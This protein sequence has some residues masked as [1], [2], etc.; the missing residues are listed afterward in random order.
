MKSFKK[1]L[2]L[3]LILTIVMTGCGTKKSS[4]NQG[5]TPAPTSE[6]QITA[7]PTTGVEPTT[8]AGLPE[9]TTKNN[10]TKY[11]LTITDTLGETI[12]FENEPK[13]MVSFSPSVTEILYALSLSDKLI[14][15]TDYCDYPSEALSKE[16]IG[17]FYNPDIEKVVSLAPDV[18]LASSLWTE[19]VIQK[20]KEVGITV[21]VV[22]EDKD[23]AGIYGMIDLIGQIFNCQDNSAK[24][25]ETMKTQIEDVTA[26]VAPLPKKTVYYV[27]GFGEYGDY[28]AG[29]DT[30]IGN[31]LTLAGGDNIAKNVSGWSYTLESL[32]DADPEVIILDNGMKDSFISSDNYKNL[33][34]VK[35]NQVYGIDNNL[36]ERQSYR[37]AEGILEVA[38]ILHPEAFQ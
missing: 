34:A 38:K 30:F 11:P 17:D 9:D 22:N 28:T 33:S 36:L 18:V 1:L 26:K 7:Q 35:N 16:S 23:V 8:P 10:V 5:I 6:A 15:R 2:T 4:E 14:G 13:T 29:G 32:V 20:F 12:T 25:V 19:D 27:V 21:A 37:V 24:L 3:G 31:L